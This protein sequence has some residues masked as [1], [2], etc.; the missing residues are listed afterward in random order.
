MKR[1]PQTQNQDCYSGKR[2]YQRPKVE[3]IKLDHEISLVMASP[4]ST[5]P[6]NQISIKK[7]F[8]FG[9]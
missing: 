6:W 5:E 7:I 3:E 8:K 9:W 1:T 2:R 4:P